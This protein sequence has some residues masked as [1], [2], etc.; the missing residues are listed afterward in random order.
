[1]AKA[2]VITGFGLNCEAETAHAIELAGSEAEQVHLTCLLDGRRSLDESQILGLIGGFFFGDHIAGTVF[3]NRLKYRLH[4]PL[5][6]FIADGK[7][8]I[9]VCNGFQTTAK[10]DILPGLD[11][12][13]RSQSVTLTHNDTGVFHDAWVHLRVDTDSPR[14]FTRGIDRIDLPARHGESN[15]VVARYVDPTTDQPTQEYSHNPN[16]SHLRPDAT[17]RGPIISLQSP[18]MV[19]TADEGGASSARTRPGPVSERGGF[20][21]LNLVYPRNLYLTPELSQSKVRACIYR[22]GPRYPVRRWTSKRS[23]RDSAPTTQST[24]LNSA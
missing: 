15:L 4:E 11:G 5:Q 16:G 9:G 14:I 17:P 7:L 21:R 24:H 18:P 3:A 10:L 1:M 13:Y 20:R 12:D 2:V 8:V 23:L 6:R 19:P 22:K